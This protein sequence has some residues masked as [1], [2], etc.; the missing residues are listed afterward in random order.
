[1]AS[2]IIFPKFSLGSKASTAVEP[3]ANHG[4]TDTQHMLRNN[5]TTAFRI[6]GDYAAL[7]LALACWL[8]AAPSSSYGQT[9]PTSYETYLRKSVVDRKTLDVFLDP[10]QI[11]WAKFDPITGYRLGNSM[12]RDGIDQSSTISTAQSNG[13]RTAQVYVGRPC[14]INTYGD[15][16]TQCHQVSDA[17]TWQEYLAGHLGEPIRNF[18]MGGFGVYQ[19]YRRMVREEQTDHGAPYII[20]YIWGD[21]HIR[22]LLRCR[23]AAI[24]PWWNDDGGRAFHNNF[25]AN[26]EMN[27]ATAHLEEHEN[28]L[29][30]RESVYRMT[31]PDWMVQALK[32]DLALNMLLYAQG[33]VTDLDMAQ[34]QRLAACL[35]Q[36][37]PGLDSPR[38]ARPVIAQLLDSYSLSATKLILTKAKEFADRNGKKFMVVLFDPARVMSALVQGKERYDQGIVDFL[39]ERQVRFFDMNPVHVE[40]FKQFRIPFGDYAKRY[41][42]GHYSPAGNHFFAYSIKNT[43][44]EWLEPKPITYQSQ[45]DRLIT[46][47][48]YLRD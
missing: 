11:S 15:S 29:P 45:A 2:L 14:R 22:S 3:Q 21:D 33:Q 34:V 46:F 41:F 38:P 13:M 42:I 23:H 27:L 5:S 10:K 32:D 37:V 40:D 24:Y 12:P 6:H 4:N 48:G 25:W 8:L 17:E 44:V 39:R 47:G 20:F 7:G 43:V 16:F 28:L 9:E 26:I 36:N 18:G 31:D 30:T 1:M 35:G 19:A